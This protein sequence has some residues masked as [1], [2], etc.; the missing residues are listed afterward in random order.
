MQIT[1]AKNPRVQSV[2]ALR[3]KSERDE[4]GLTRVEGFEEIRLVVT[5][6]F[7]PLSLYVCP[8]LIGAGDERDLLARIERSGVEVIEV[9]R[10][11]FDRMAYRQGGDGWIGVFPTPAKRLDEIALAEPAFVVVAEG[12]EKPGNLGAILR[13]ADAAGVQAIVSA[14]GI[15]DWGNPNVIRAS[16]GAVY[17]MKVAEASNEQTLAWLRRYGAQIVV[18]TPDAERP[19][20]RANMTGSVA[21]VVGAEHAGVSRFWLDHADAAV[22]I[23]MVGRVDSLN[24]ATSCAL[25]V[26][27]VVR[28]RDGP[29]S[30]TG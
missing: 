1:S 10:P 18:A 26:Y 3:D 4:T 19:Y 28:Q 9:R 24:V 8:E 12:I 17:G 23:P 13:T 15:T 30:V 25:M 7:R 11:V 6:G 27:E 20:T 16:K 14:D 5:S 22:R 2:I 21:I 29:A